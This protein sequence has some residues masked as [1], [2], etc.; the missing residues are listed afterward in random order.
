VAGSW[1]CLTIPAGAAAAGTPTAVTEIPGQGF[2]D[3]RARMFVGTDSGYVLEYSR[4]SQGTVTLNG[5]Y[6]LGGLSAIHDLGPVPQTSGIMLGVASGARL[7][8]YR[9]GSGSPQLLFDL[10]HPTGSKVKAFRTF[11]P[12]DRL[13]TSSTTELHV[14]FCD[15]RSDRVFYTKLPPALL[16]SLPLNIYL[17]PPAFELPS[18]GALLPFTGSL[19]LLVGP[20]GDV[21]FRPGYLNGASAVGCMVQ[22]SASTWQPCTPCPIVV[23]GDVDNS[24]SV[25]AADV[26]RMVAFVFKGGT[27]LAPCR[28]AGDV[29]CSGVINA[30]DVIG[31]INYVFKGGTAL[32]NVCTQFNGTWTC[33]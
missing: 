16:G 15:G 21:Y 28:A 7:S 18:G 12:G 5:Q 22:V 19:A 17:V 29:N 1:G 20:Q 2:S 8:G 33:P 26:I 30:A 11:E 4:S 13:L 25:S 10:T 24:G 14:A 31:T 6:D 9:M 3:G 32:C 27:A 23:T